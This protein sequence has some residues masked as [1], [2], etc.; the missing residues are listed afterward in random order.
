MTAVQAKDIAFVVYYASPPKDLEKNVNFEDKKKLPSWAEW[1]R[2]IE[3]VQTMIHF[4]FESA[5]ITHKQCRLV[6]L[7]DNSTEFSMDKISLGGTS[8]G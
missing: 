4:N 5:R 8:W 7:T 2:D 6:I 1:D 3:K